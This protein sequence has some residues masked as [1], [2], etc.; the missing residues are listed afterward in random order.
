VAKKFRFNREFGLHWHQRF[1]RIFLT[2]LATVLFSVGF[3]IRRIAVTDYSYLRIQAKEIVREQY[4]RLIAGMEFESKA[5]S[6]PDIEISLGREALS[7]KPEKPVSTSQTRVNERRNL[8]SKIERN[9]SLSVGTGS[10][11]IYSYLPEENNDAEYINELTGIL[12]KEYRPVGRWNKSGNRGIRTATNLDPGDFDKPM[13]DVFNYITER[14]GSIY[15]DVTDELVQEPIAMTG[16]RDPE[17]I[18][19]VINNNQTMIEYCFRKEL[20]T[21]SQ[22]KGYVKVQFN[23]SFEGYVLPESI[24]ILNSTLRN[25]QVEQCIKHYLRRIK[26]FQRLDESMG[27]ARVVQKFVFN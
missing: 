22:L 19:Q 11:D 7:V 5:I 2:I 8:E 23:I 20:R 24:K 1:D 9:I 21:N 6:A 14:Q 16:Y 18:E 17:E 3:T 10:S 26:T 25:K 4:V 27:V 12:S 13:R 15:I